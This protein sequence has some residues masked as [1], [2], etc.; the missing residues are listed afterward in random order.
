MDGTVQEQ[1][2]RYVLRFERHLKHPV[3]K[4]WG[5]LTESDRLGDWLAEGTIESRPD[6]RAELTFANAPTPGHGTVLA[7]TVREVD[8]PR[9]LEYSWRTEEGDEEP[10]RWELFPEDGGTRLVLTHTL[11]RPDGMRASLGAEGA[12]L[13]GRAVGCLAGWHGHLDLLDLAVAGR[14]APFSIVRWAELYVRYLGARYV[15][16]GRPLVEVVA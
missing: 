15:S 3:E 8:P 16:A 14:P 10:V 2:G 6:G 12:G 4:V 5:A 1:D 11:L 7:G 9:L 13:D